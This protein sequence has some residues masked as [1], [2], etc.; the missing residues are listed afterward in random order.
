MSDLDFLSLRATRRENP[1]A[2]AKALAS[3]QRRK[4]LRGDGKLMVIACDHPARGALSVGSD[5]YAM[6]D[7]E[8]LLRRLVTALSVP[9][10]DGLL[11]TAD[12]VD[13][14]ALLGALE[15]KVIV[16]SLN[17]GGLRGASF[18]MDD[19]FGAYTVAA[20]IDAGLDAVK[21]LTRINF[22]D[23]GTAGTLE[24]TAH[25]VTRAAAAQMP[26]LIEPFISEW[27]DGDVRN[28]LSAE[29]V[30]RSM[31]IAAGLGSSSAYTWLKIP[32]VQQMERVMAAT[33]LPTVI[34][35]GDPGNDSDGLFSDWAHAMTIDGVVG[36][37][38][39]RSLLYPQSGST[40][41]AV[42]RAVEVVHG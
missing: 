18:E 14:L 20:A 26:I 29:A 27:I 33:T 23:P 11:A 10:V 13:D 1:E 22:S 36:L 35:G 4:L 30:I 34:L 15:D 5:P 42:A 6:A 21:T 40:H 7:R 25:S 39:G 24:N 41:D 31:A 38:V 3:R 17:R 12:L 9:G 37:M 16:G 28:D 19:R 8:E 32:Y 2:I